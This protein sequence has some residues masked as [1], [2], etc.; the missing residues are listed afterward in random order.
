M[1]ELRTAQERIKELERALGNKTMEID[2]PGRAGRGK[3]DPA[4]TACLSDD[5]AEAGPELP[6]A[7]ISRAWAYRDS[8]GRPRRYARAEDR[9]VT[10]QIRTVIRIRAPKARGGC[11]PSSIGNSPPG[12]TSSASGG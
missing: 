12:T 2:P 7:G 4:S 8:V 11:G 9:V 1:S 3:K 6:D 5:L 10:A